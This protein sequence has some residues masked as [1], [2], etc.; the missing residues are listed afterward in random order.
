MKKI[1]FIVLL[2][3]TTFSANCDVFFGFAPHAAYSFDFIYSYEKVKK[4][5]SSTVFWGGIGVLRDGFDDMTSYGLELGV[6]K[7]HYF[8][9]EKYNHFC[10]SSSLSTTYMRN[11][12]YGQFSGNSIGIIPGFKL[13]YKAQISRSAFLEPY[14]SISFPFMI[15]L[16]HNIDFLEIPMFTV[17]AR[18][19]FVKLKKDKKSDYQ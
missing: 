12:I 8:Q 2:I 1:I 17:G 7:R 6:E 19:G 16:K 4:I 18:I 5:K 13:N 15:D 11:I 9:S 10:I 3:S 14:I